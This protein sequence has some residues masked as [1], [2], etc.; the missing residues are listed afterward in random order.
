MCFRKHWNTLNLMIPYWYNILCA[1]LDSG[2][3]YICFIF[4]WT[5]AKPQ[6]M[7]PCWY[8]A[9]STSFA[10]MKETNFRVSFLDNW[11]TKTTNSHLIS[12]I[13]VGH[14]LL[15]PSSRF[16]YLESYNTQLYDS[17]WYT[18]FGCMKYYFWT[19]ESGTFTP[20]LSRALQHSNLWFPIDTMNFCG[21]S[22]SFALEKVA[23]F[24]HSFL[25]GF[26]TQRPDT[27]NWL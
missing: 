10:I 15:L 18:E 19:T 2:K 27:M 11:R 25:E 14:L 4:H 21:V 1:V 17:S 5:L 24:C 7:I 22:A 23:H 20:F 16:S 8:R 3:W 6:L 12:W 9:G 13:C 26:N